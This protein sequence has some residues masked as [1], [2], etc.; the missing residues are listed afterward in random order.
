MGVSELEIEPIKRTSLPEQVMERIKQYIMLHDLQPG[1]RLPG[2]RELAKTLGV[3]RTVMREALQSLQA[4]GVLEIQPGNGIF[5]TPVNFENLTKHLGFAI[6][7]QPHQM[8]HLVDARIIFERGVLELVAKNATSAEIDSLEEVVQ[9]MEKSTSREEDFESDLEFHLRLVELT[10]NPILME[11]T[12]LLT[13]FFREGQQALAVYDPKFSRKDAREH[14]K[15]IK[16]IKE[17]NMVRAQN[18]LE[19][20]IRGW[21][22][23]AGV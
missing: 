13:R 15:L 5:V 17:K 22:R 12:S 19:K 7:R 2:E 3:S 23:N 20:G 1:V 21:N 8:D 9:K 14:R 6:Q 18:I 10:R 4:V 16:A 11:F